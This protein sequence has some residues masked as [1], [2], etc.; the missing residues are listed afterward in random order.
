MTRAKRYLFLTRAGRASPFL[1]ELGIDHRTQHSPKRDEHD[2]PPAYRAL[3]AWRLT[4]AQQDGIPAY[5][6]FHDRT[7]ADIAERHPAT[8]AELAGISGVGPV[9]LERYGNEVLATL[10]AHPAAAADRQ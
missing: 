3:K 1:G 7:L 2:L 6:V 10:V 9:K 4:R 5:V 8:A